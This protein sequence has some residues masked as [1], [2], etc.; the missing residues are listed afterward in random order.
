MVE[1]DDTEPANYWKGAGTWND[2]GMEREMG[3]HDAA[4]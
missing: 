2:E 4:H 1:N 3:E